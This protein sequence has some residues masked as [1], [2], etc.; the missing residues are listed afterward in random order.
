MDIIFWSFFQVK[1]SVIISNK[2]GIRELLYEL[3]N[4]LRLKEIKKD[5]ENLS[6]S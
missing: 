6:T 1:W 5:Q 4:G 3:L 2:H